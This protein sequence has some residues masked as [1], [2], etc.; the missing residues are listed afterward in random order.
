MKR[1]IFLILCV[2]VL[3]VLLYFKMRTPA[4]NQDK[5]AP[6]FEA[7]LIDGS[8]FKLS[9]LRGKYVLLD[10]WGS[11]CPPCRR[12]NP[13]LVTLYDQYNS[14]GL[15]IVSVALEKNDRTWKK[16]IAK[17]GLRWPYHIM[18]TSRLVATDAL[19]LKY[20]VTD[21]PTKYLIN[22][23]GKIVGVNMTKEEMAKVIKDN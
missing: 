16:A 14:R 9:D 20:Q 8:A 12:D 21:L 5:I 4:S 1:S 18:R 2:L 17:D 7:T 15:E 6:D 23:Q 13:N 22:P 3:A 11:W 10:F 19:A